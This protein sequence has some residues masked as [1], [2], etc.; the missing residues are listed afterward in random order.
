MGLFDG[1]GDY[2]AT[3][4]GERDYRVQRTVDEFQIYGDA[5]K[6]ISFGLATL[7]CGVFGKP[8][9]PLTSGQRSR[10][11]ENIER[12]Y[13]RGWRELPEEFRPKLVTGMRAAVLLVEH[14]H[15]RSRTPG[16]SVDRPDWLKDAQANCR[17]LRNDLH[18]MV[19][20]AEIADRASMRALFGGDEASEPP[21]AIAFL[22]AA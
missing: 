13:R 10:L 20:Q 6:Q 4:E 5:A 22:T 19:L 17:C 3:P 8:D 11:L 7:E 12:A 16:K 9:L 1:E 21:P 15:H 2:P 14:W 18:N